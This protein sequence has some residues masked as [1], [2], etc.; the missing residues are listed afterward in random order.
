[1]PVTA[2]TDR[3]S[4]R[5]CLTGAMVV[6]AFMVNGPAAIAQSAQEQAQ[7][8]SGINEAVKAFDNVPRL[9]NLSPQTKREIVDF[10]VG[11]A[12]FVLA[13]EMGHGLINEMNMPVLG[14]EE[15]A[16][17]SFAIVTALK[18]GT[19][20]SERALLEAG[21]GLFLSGQRDKKEGNVLAFYDEH[22]LDLQRAYN[23]V[24]FM[25]GANPDKYK[26]LAADTKLPQQ[27]QESCVYEW[28]NT[29]WSWDEMLQK[30]LRSASQ[31]KIAV[32]V[33]YE[34]SKNF[35]IQAELM[36]HM[37]L[38]EAFATH[39]ADR[40]AWP[41]PFTIEARSCGR[42]NARWRQRVLTFCYEI[43]NEFI[44]LYLEYSSEIPRKYRAA[45][46]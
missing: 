3:I 24:C 15:D 8:A 1:M 30:H 34:E 14:R 31:P 18:M 27:R 16:A 44:E 46:E 20:F 45:A 26:Q 5:I 19:A 29:S 35:T 25:V 40:Y 28:K 42:A 39:A 33:E 41:N 2:M 37:G 13:H 10:V 9:K 17:D 12:V 11:N 7:I 6:A 21:K 23:V 36:R 4:Y 22:G 32:K 43:A 38:L